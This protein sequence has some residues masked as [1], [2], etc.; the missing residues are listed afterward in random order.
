M[1]A[2]EIL[3]CQTGAVTSRS[4]GGVTIKFI[5]PEL[6]P[7]EAGALIQLHGKNVCVSIVPEDVAPDEV[8]KVST[9]LEQKTASQRLRGVIYCLYSQQKPAGPFQ[10]FYEEEM[11]KFIAHVKAKLDPQ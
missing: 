3:H 11:E 8:V 6:R 1:K 4:D 2:I 9:P 10:P 5:T 7:S